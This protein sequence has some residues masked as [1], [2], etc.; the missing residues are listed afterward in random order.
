M[1][2]ADF[3]ISAHI[4]DFNAIPGLLFHYTSAATFSQILHSKVFRFSELQRTNDPRETHQLRFSLRG[5]VVNGTTAQPAPESFN[6]SIREGIKVACM[7]IDNSDNDRDVQ[8]YL[9]RGFARP[10]NWAQYGDNHRGVCLVFAKDSFI[11][12]AESVASEL[13][14]T[15]MA[16]PVRYAD[17]QIDSREGGDL[18][19][20]TMDDFESDPVALAARV[21]HEWADEL[22]FTK[23]ADWGS[24]REFRVA[25]LEPPNIGVFEVPL[26][27]SLAAVVLG[28]DFPE[29]EVVVLPARLELAGLRALPVFRMDWSESLPDITSI[30][31]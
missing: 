7:T 15:V 1:H 8:G 31:R 4:G 26:G 10:R 20:L 3:D 16:K 28:A 22:V 2:L 6:R 14:G 23:L 27:A 13:A 19:D 25:V 29:T 17:R 30:E 5:R 11:R 21:R 12:S 24:E 9:R 18:L